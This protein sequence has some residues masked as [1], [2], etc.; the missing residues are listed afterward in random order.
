MTHA[1]LI[2]Q[3]GTVKVRTYNQADKKLKEPCHEY[4]IKNDGANTITRIENM[5]K[6]GKITVQCAGYVWEVITG[7][8]E[9]LPEVSQCHVTLSIPPCLVLSH[10]FPLP[11]ELEHIPR[12]PHIPR[13]SPS[14]IPG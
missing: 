8:V 3:Y 10:V 9:T 11:T 7:Q 12:I 14:A 2:G 13:G 4:E 6:Q 5:D 1:W